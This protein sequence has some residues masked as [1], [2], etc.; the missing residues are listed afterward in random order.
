MDFKH[1]F[2]MGMHTSASGKG[3][4]TDKVST[5]G[6]HELFLEYEGFLSPPSSRPRKLSTATPKVAQ[7][8]TKELRLDTKLNVFGHMSRD[9]KTSCDKPPTQ[10]SGLRDS[11]EDAPSRP[12]TIPARQKKSLFSRNR[13]TRVEQEDSSK[14]KPNLSLA[15]P[16]EQEKTSNNLTAGWLRRCISTTSKSHQPSPPPPLPL[17]LPSPF[18]KLPP[19]DRF[20]VFDENDLTALPAL[21]VYEKEPP[22]P[23]EKVPSGAAAR[24]AA[25]AQNEVLDTMRN[26]RL[27][28]PK[29][30]RD[31]E[32]GVGIEVRDRGE[33]VTDIY[34]PIVRKG[35]GSFHLYDTSANRCC[36]SFE[37]AS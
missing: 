23:P 19:A 27:A 16:P 35:K 24:A 2:G 34:I 1:L 4:K 17:P 18:M 7:G 8:G 5:A 15:C 11:F 26:L 36:R 12:R 29:L 30:T 9:S 28:E 33:I 22:K 10:N 20:P 13:S 6:A 37:C 32:S 14:R 21:P 31:S 3:R 25:A